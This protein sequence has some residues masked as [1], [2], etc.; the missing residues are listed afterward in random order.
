MTKV[1]HADAVA[2]SS[3]IC[4]ILSFFASQLTILALLLKQEGAGFGDFEMIYTYFYTLR[5]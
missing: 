5:C 1:A 3:F 4:F 2:G